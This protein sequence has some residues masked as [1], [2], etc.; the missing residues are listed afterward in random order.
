MG[1]VNVFKGLGSER[2]IYN[3]NGRIGK[4]LDLDWGHCKMLLGDREITK[5]YAVREDDVVYIR[6]YPGAVTTGLLIGMA[7]A[8]VVAAGVGV[9][10]GVTA[11]NAAR[12]AR[13]KLDNALNRIG[14]DNRRRDVESIPHLSGARNEFAEG[15]QAPIILGRHLFAPYF[16][17]EPYMRPSGDDG[18][19]LYWYGTFLVGQTGLSLEK[20][21]NGMVDLVSFNDTVYRN[22]PAWTGWSRPAGATVDGGVLRVTGDTVVGATPALQFD[23]AGRVVMIRARW[24][25]TAGPSRINVSNV[26]AGGPNQ[27]D[28]L[29]R[30]WAWYRVAGAQGSRV[31]GIFAVGPRPPEFEFEISDLY[32]GYEGIIT[33][34]GTYAFDRPQNLDPESPPPFHDPENRVEVRQGGYF[35]EGLFNDRWVDSLEA[36]VEIGRKPKDNAATLPNI[37][38]PDA[39]LIF[40]DDNGPDPVIRESARFPM[41]VEVEILVDGLHGWDS[42]N[43]EPTTAQIALHVEWSPDGLTGWTH[44]RIDGWQWSGLQHQGIVDPGSGFHNRLTRN[45]T[46]QMRFVAPIDL[47]HSVYS[48]DGK[49]VYIRVTRLTHQHVGSIRSR[50]LLTA[51][52]TRQYSPRETREAMASEDPRLVPAKNIAPSLAG[53]F[54]RIGIRV[55]ANQNTQEHMDRFNAIA[56]MTGRTWGG[57]GWSG[58]KTATSN[59]AAVALEVMTGL[60]HEPSRHGDPEIDLA[61][62][63]GLYRWCDSREV[64]V[65]GSG[66]R[67]VKL[68]SCGVLTGAARKIDVLRAVLAACDAGVYADEFGRLKFWYD[69][70]KDTPDAMLNPQ[71]IVSMS[72]SRD[73]HRRAH[74]QAVRFV[75]RDGDWSERTERVLRPRVEEVQGANTFDPVNHEYVTDHYHAMWLARR[76][77]A[78]EILQPG[79]ITVEVG[80]EGRHYAP[81]TLLKVAHEGFRIGIG[82]GEIVENIIADNEI[83]GVRTMERFDIHEDRD[84]WVDFYVV[85]GDRN[86]VVTRQIR[87]VNEYTDVLT[88]TAPIPPGRDA[89]AVGNIVSV[90]DGLREGIGYKVWESKRCVVMD[91]SPT[92]TGYRLTLARYDDDIYRTSAID[93]IPE[94]RSRILPTAPRVYGAQP[95]YPRDGRDGVDGEDGERGPPGTDGV[96]PRVG[97]NGNWWIGGHDTGVKA[98]GSDGTPGA[99]PHIGPNGNWWVGGEDTGVPARGPPGNT[100]V[101]GPNGNW[102]IGGTDTGLPADGREITSIDYHYQLNN[103]GTAPGLDA[104]GWLTTRP[105]PTAASRFLWARTTFNFNRGNPEREVSLR[106][107]HGQ[108]GPAGNYTEMRFRTNNTGVTNPGNPV[109]TDRNPANWSTSMT[110]PTSAGGSVWMIQATVNAA[111]ALVGTWTTPVMLSSRGTNGANGLTPRIGENGNWWVGTTD[112]GILAKGEDGVSINFRGEWVAN[113]IDGTW[114]EVNDV[115]TFEG[116]TFMCVERNRG[117][118]RPWPLTNATAAR[119][120]V[121]MADKGDDGD[122]GR[123]IDSITLAFI[124]RDTS[125]VPPATDP[126]WA[127]WD[128]AN[129]TPTAAARWLWKRE[130]IAFTSGTPATQDFVTLVSIHGQTG[131]PGQDGREITSIDYHYQLNNTGTAPGLD[132]SGWLTTRPLPTAASRFLWA[133]T[134][135]N[136]NRGNP[137]REVSLRAMHGMD[138][139]TPR[140]GE[141]GN[142]WIGG[143]DTGIKAHGED[144]KFTDYRFAVSDDVSLPPGGVYRN[145]P[146]W[147]GWGQTWSSGFQQ[148]GGVTREGGLLVITGRAHTS[149]SF[150]AAERNRAGDVLI[151][152]ARQTEGALGRLDSGGSFPSGYRTLQLGMLTREWRV[153]AVVLP[154][155]GRTAFSLHRSNRN[156]AEGRVEISDLFV[157]SGFA[158]DWHDTPP[159]MDANQF[160]WMTRADF[161][162]AEQL[163]DWSAPARITGP[164]GGRGATGPAGNYTETRFRT[165]NTGTG[166]PG[167]PT[168]NADRNPANWSTSMTAPTSAGGSVWMIQA[169]VNAADQLVGTWGAPVM[170]SSRGTNGTPGMPG[171][172]ILSIEFRLQRT[173]TAT[174]PTQPWGDAAWLVNAPALDATNRWLWKM[175]RI[176]FD[177]DRGDTEDFVTLIAVHGQ[178]GRGISSVTYAFLRNNS[179]TR[180]A[181]NAA[182]WA[183]WNAANH[184]PDAANRFL[185]YRETTVYTEGDPGV[186]VGLESIHGQTGGAGRGIAS[187][188]Y[189][190]RTSA[191]ATQPPATPDGTNAANSWVTTQPA[192]DATNRWLWF[193]QT[194]AFTDGSSNQVIVGLQA[195][196][197]QTGNYYALIFRR[198]AAQPATPTGNS[199]SGWGDAPPATGEDPLWM[200]RGIMSAQGVLQGT[201]SVPVR[202][203]REGLPGLGIDEIPADAH[204]YWPF[205]DL[206]E[207]PDNPAGT[208]YRNDPAWTGWG[209]FVSSGHL[210]TGAV[211]REGGVLVVTGTSVTQ[212]SFPAAERNRAGDVL[213]V[214]ARQTEGALGRLDSGGSFPSGYRTL[215]L[216]MLTR[217][218]RVYAVALPE[219]GRTA[220]SLHRS[221]RNTAEGRVEISD[222]YVGDGSFLSPLFDWANENHASMPAGGGVVPARGRHGRALEF[223]GGFVTTPVRGDFFTRDFTVSMWL[224]PSEVSGGWQGAFGVGASRRFSV[225]INTLGNLAVLT[226]NT[227]RGSWAVPLNQWTH[228]IVRRSGGTITVRVNNVLRSTITAMPDTSTQFA[229]IGRPG[230]GTNS[231]WRGLIDEVALFDR[232]LDDDGCRALYL[233]TLSTL[234]T[235]QSPR[236]ETRYRGSTAIADTANTG[237]ING[238]A[239]HIDNFVSYTGPDLGTNSIWRPGNVLQ[240]SGS[241]WRLVRLEA[242]TAGMYWIAMRDIA[243]YAPTSIASRALIMELVTSE[244]FIE[245]LFAETIELH[246]TRGEIRSRGFTGLAGAVLGFL[247]RA[248]DGRIEANNIHTRNMNAVDM[249]ATNA[250]VEGDITSG[251]TFNTN[252]TIRDANALGGISSRGNDSVR[253]N[254]LVATGSV[255]LGGVLPG[256]TETFHTRGVTIHNR[257]RIMNNSFLLSSVLSGTSIARLALWNWLNARYANMGLNNLHHPLIGTIGMTVGGSRRHITITHLGRVNATEYRLF[258]MGTDGIRYF[259]WVPNTGTN[260]T[261]MNRGAN[262]SIDGGTNVGTF[263]SI[264]VDL[265]QV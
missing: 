218:W 265:A 36:N 212:R 65:A 120:W 158:D 22:D 118:T 138:G 244:A 48:E 78:R 54:C 188:T 47:P 239:M 37:N 23:L 32:V 263:T 230:T 250:T 219:A 31:S 217:E 258:G 63:G 27:T 193:R 163:T 81:G 184:M 187:I 33:P 116:R 40:I 89:P 192:T 264:T 92:A 82:S 222:L 252:G 59:P 127:A 180:P 139:L 152:R 168:N 42:E 6:E 24:T 66:L 52:R 262:T 103:T 104:S 121:L 249:T 76:S 221:N 202:I 53:K 91:S 115:V 101:V 229:A 226:N 213:I 29:T 62:L 194:T 131:V 141:N 28:T 21:R 100:P 96:N 123:G 69:D 197:G 57:S 87:S 161:R 60:I 147:T 108:T 235:Y 17:S 206:P 77:M 243:R 11:R 125:T 234:A 55:K 79:E 224:N 85:D 16:L 178:T 253:L 61:S 4:N 220:F 99:S 157:L 216:G 70:F 254:G 182:G 35:E 210:D 105:L 50:T 26:A 119:R 9:W 106:A 140:I 170:L 64:T 177:G 164:Q 132:A 136:F 56:S 144:G 18:M 19:D 228:V 175:E 215:Q 257:R 198:A 122:D 186:R 247:L 256:Q 240:W 153:Y 149:R 49:P 248:R 148:T 259:I 41:R 233:T 86:H 34:S 143:T 46:R 191:N 130:R 214:R 255:E 145:D 204:A 205:D 154:E 181:E 166:N 110:A 134:T 199:P 201:W 179:D 167:A 102:W 162:G 203:E 3:F 260:M 155:A 137:E 232:A 238:E 12:D 45:T 83:V 200:S 185:W 72:E 169:W 126:A 133:R 160:L 109:S 129:H 71:R 94:Y 73:L 5:N 211:T 30:E 242:D 227:S 195:V 95:S 2:T 190:W 223:L 68:E 245:F 225:E 112:T 231:P 44:A 135:F 75:D 98:E 74:G 241:V 150:P 165:N 189:R 97:E 146:A 80:R 20:I 208:V 8:G 1:I 38:S 25:G 173:G 7:V 156:T 183:A 10:A 39:P 209:R 151:V 196:H 111:N 176:T 67:P 114:Y 117:A 261:L 84:Y 43:G 13:R 88:F 236:R 51:I 124:R 90:I 159:P 251:Q 107:M 58:G 174:A 14:D 142:W 113:G 246:G 93:A 171:R 237:R 15:R 128:A 207:M 172:G